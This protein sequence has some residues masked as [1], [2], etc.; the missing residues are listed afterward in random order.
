MSVQDL[1]ASSNSN[2]SFQTTFRL[3]ISFVLSLSFFARQ[4]AYRRGDFVRHTTA[5]TLM[6]GDEVCR[7]LGE[8]AA[9]ARIFQTGCHKGAPFVRVLHLHRRPGFQRAAAGGGKVV[10]GKA[11]HGRNAAGYRLDDVLT[12]AVH[13]AAADKGD[14]GAKVVGKEFAHAVADPDLGLL[15]NRQV[16]AA[17]LNGITCSSNLRTTLAMEDAF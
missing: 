14:I 7:L 17:F 13:E 3:W 12:A 5:G 4:M 2:P 1:G 15:G 10:G 6:A 8:M 16:V 9:L 11:E